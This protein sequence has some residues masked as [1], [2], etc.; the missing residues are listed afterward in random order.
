MWQLVLLTSA[1]LL[2]GCGPPTKA[3]IGVTTVG[4][5][6]TVLVYACDDQPHLTVRV[7]YGKGTREN[8]AIAGRARRHQ[9]VRLSL[10]NPPAPWTVSGA[11]VP[12]PQNAEVEADTEDGA[13]YR[14]AADVYFVPSQVP[15]SPQIGVKDE[16]N[17]KLET[18][19]ARAFKKQAASAC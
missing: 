16:R 15:A 14:L 13:G 2:S 19:S 12:L 1:V 17:N 9:T 5:E 18:L 11:K 6:P 8:Y 10:V 4:V 7:Y 3:A